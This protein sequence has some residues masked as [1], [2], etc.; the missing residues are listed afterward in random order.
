MRLKKSK[1]FGEALWPVG[2]WSTCEGLCWRQMQPPK[3]PTLAYTATAS[4]G[5]TRM[6]RYV[7]GYVR[8]PI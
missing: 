8:C 5:R 1:V 3:P 4:A 7:H 6:R 2:G